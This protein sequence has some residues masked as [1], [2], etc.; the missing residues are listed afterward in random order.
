MG[1]IRF[2]FLCLFFLYTLQQ[3]HF[4]VF[5]HYKID[6][7]LQA[8]TFALLFSTSLS[9]TWWRVD[10]FGVDTKCLMT[11]TLMHC[12]RQ[13]EHQK[14]EN[15]FFCSLGFSARFYYL[16]HFISFHSCCSF[17][18]V[19]SFCI[20]FLCV[21]WVCMCWLPLLPQKTHACL[22]LACLFALF[23]WQFLAHSRK[24]N[25]IK[26]VCCVRARCSWHVYL[27]LH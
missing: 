2:P 9:M 13:I 8:K 23:L 7:M 12:I 3:K 20:L 15:L 6:S 14:Q 25:D 21:S 11:K 27:K 24:T 4:C 1:N 10:I 17:S 19:K 26:R 16:L 18:M 5:A 22:L